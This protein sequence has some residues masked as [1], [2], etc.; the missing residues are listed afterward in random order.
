MKNDDWGYFG[1]GI[2]GYVHY[3]QF[4]TH[5]RQMLDKPCGKSYRNRP[6]TQGSTTAVWVFCAVV[7][8]LYVLGH[9]LLFVA[10]YPI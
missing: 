8:G 4:M 1:K 3:N 9:I 7:I 10:H 5:D 2:D 6:A